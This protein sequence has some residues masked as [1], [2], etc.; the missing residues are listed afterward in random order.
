MMLLHIILQTDSANGIS[1]LFF[2]SHKGCSKTYKM[3]LNEILL[4]NNNNKKFRS[5]KSK[6]NIQK[7]E[8]GPYR[9]FGY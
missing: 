1:H 8:I 5:F 2:S 9:G 3:H 6:E 7:K 4:I